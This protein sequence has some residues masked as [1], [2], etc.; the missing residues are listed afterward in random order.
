[1]EPFNDPFHWN[2]SVDIWGIHGALQIFIELFG[3]LPSSR[4]LYRSFWSWR[5]LYVALQQLYGASLP[6]SRELYRAFWWKG[7]VPHT[8]CILYI[9]IF[10]VYICFEMNSREPETETE[11]VRAGERERPS[12]RSSQRAGDWARGRDTE[13]LSGSLSHICGTT[14]GPFE[15]YDQ[16]LS[17]CQCWCLGLSNAKVACGVFTHPRLLRFGSFL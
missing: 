1:M 7:F 4:E 2:I 11:R 12:Q 15:R 6:S 8:G 3:D 5:V 14:E 13:I 16:E 10:R 17:C 9:Q